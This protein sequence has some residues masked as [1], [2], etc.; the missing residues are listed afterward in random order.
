MSETAFG[1]DGDW[2]APALTP[3]MA[4]LA[5]LR[6]TSETHLM[7][8]KGAVGGREANEPPGDPKDSDKTPRGGTQGMQPSVQR[9]ST[10]KFD[11]TVS[12]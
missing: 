12:V 11:E 7:P 3:D 8:G 10:F 6:T 5:A 2:I 9:F 1:R 4:Q